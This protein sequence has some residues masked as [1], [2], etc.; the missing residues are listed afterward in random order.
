MGCDSIIQL[1]LYIGQPGLDT[2]FIQIS[3]INSYEL[4]GSIY[5]ENG[6]YYQTITDQYGCDSTIS[7]ELF[8]E[9]LTTIETEKGNVR[10][11]PNPS[12]DG[13][14]Y[15]SGQG[16]NIISLT[17]ILGNKIDCT[18]SNDTINLSNH[19][20]GTYFLHIK[21]NDELIL[22]LKILYL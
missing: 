17:D 14:F 3:A 7:I 12:I 9:Y 22:P 4:N 20:K 5:N 18:Y 10:I 19:S 1:N 6:Q 16:I 2:T 15:I 11:F 13:I 21:V 8:V